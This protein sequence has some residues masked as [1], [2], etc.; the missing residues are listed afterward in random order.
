[1]NDKGQRIG[2]IRVSRI[3]YP[4]TFIVRGFS[5]IFMHQ[6][7]AQSLGYLTKISAQRIARQKL[8]KK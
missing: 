4:L 6:I 2:K 8:D 3:S 7:E 5:S 1:V